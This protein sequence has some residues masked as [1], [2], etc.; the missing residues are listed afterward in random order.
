VYL[1]PYDNIDNKSSILSEEYEVYSVVIVQ[2]EHDSKSI[3]KFVIK[4]LTYNES[5]GLLDSFINNLENYTGKKLDIGLVNDFRIKN[6]NKSR[7]ENKFSIPQYIILISE[8]ELNDTFRE[9][10][11]WDKFYEMYPNS[12]GVIEIS[13]VGFN[14]NYS[15][16]LVYYGEYSHNLGGHGDLVFLIKEEGKWIIKEQVPLWIS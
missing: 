5:D 9:M 2:Q 14:N 13:R 6:E 10:D 16:A 12:S 15:Q 1:S 11:G 7:L 8:K 4:R 3:D